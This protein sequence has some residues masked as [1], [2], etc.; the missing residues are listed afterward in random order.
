MI[1]TALFVALNKEGVKNAFQLH[2]SQYKID[3]ASVYK[4]SRLPVRSKQPFWKKIKVVS[5]EHFKQMS[6]K[7]IT[8]F[9]NGVCKSK[10]G[11]FFV[12]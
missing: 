8:S 2:Y 10:N 12:A 3:T 9:D 5:I 1:S 6:Q 7:L 4:V 11:T